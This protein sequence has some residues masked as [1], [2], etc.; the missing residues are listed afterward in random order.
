MGARIREE[1]KQTL[2]L[3]LSNHERKRI[4]MNQIES[5]KKTFPEEKAIPSTDLLSVD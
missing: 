1:L 5:T 4:I 2:I 3:N